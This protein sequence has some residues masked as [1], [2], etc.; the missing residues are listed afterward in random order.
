[1]S[2]FKKEIDKLGRGYS[3]IRTILP[4]FTNLGVLDKFQI[5]SMGVLMDCFDGNEER[6][7]KV[8]AAVDML[9]EKGY[10]AEFTAPGR[11][12]YC[13]P[14]YVSSCMQKESIKKSHNI[15]DIS[16]GNVTISANTDIS[17]PESLTFHFCND[18]L[19]LYLW[20]QKDILSA[21]R[22]AKLRSLSSGVMITIKSL[23]MTMGFYAQRVCVS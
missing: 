18:T 2:G 12:L 23:S 21:P 14:S 17:I 3:E 15:F 6:K 5:F 1:M 16:V 9:V 7:E 20:A 4:L 10:L 8:H 22:Y 13:L 11:T 19:F